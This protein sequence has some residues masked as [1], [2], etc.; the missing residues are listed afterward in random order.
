MLTIIKNVINAVITEADLLH[1]LAVANF[2]NSLG[3]S[4][5]PCWCCGW[6]AC[7]LREPTTEFCGFYRHHDSPLRQ[8]H[9]LQP[10]RDCKYNSV[11]LFWASH[12][13]RMT[14]CNE[15]VH[16]AVAAES[17]TCRT[18][19]M[20]LI[21]CQL[22]CKFFSQYDCHRYRLHRFCCWWKMCEAR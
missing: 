21:K 7:D 6:L 10:W 4:P 1:A 3:G 18:H 13:M 19:S 5:A 15:A 17:R 2:H 14:A 11:P 20:E 8:R 16:S 22:S 9:W 12:R